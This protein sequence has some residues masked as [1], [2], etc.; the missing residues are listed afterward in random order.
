M[1]RISYFLI[2]FFLF[3]NAASSFADIFYAN[4][5]GKKKQIA[6]TFDDGPGIN[7]S[8]ILMIIK[9]KNIKAT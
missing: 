4:G 3:F 6:L 9:E 1:K 5:D 8:E 2:L 7:T